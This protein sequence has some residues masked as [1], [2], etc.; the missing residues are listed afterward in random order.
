MPSIENLTANEPTAALN[1]SDQTLV[2]L[3]VLALFLSL[4][5]SL[6]QASSK[7]LIIHGPLDK[8]HGFSNSSSKVMDQALLDWPF[9]H[10][11]FWTIMGM[12]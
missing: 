3:K 2:P 4:C 10:A 1:T 12:V 8:I 5:H 7:N 11:Y 9:K 6:G